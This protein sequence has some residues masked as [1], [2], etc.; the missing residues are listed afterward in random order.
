MVEHH[1]SLTLPARMATGSVLALLAALGLA[2]ASSCT[3]DGDSGA[4][5]STASG[6]HG[7]AGAAAGHG[8]GGQ[9]NAGA[10]GGHGGTGA[11]G[12]SGGATGGAGGGDGGG[13]PCAGTT[14]GN[15]GESEPCAVVSDCDGQMYCN[16]TSCICYPP[17]ECIE[18]ADCAQ[19]DNAWVHDGCAGT[20]ACTNGL[21][22][23]ICN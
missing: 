13:N 22:E 2:L 1:R 12:G 21:C 14:P 19:S 20:A 17:R 9:G 18:V 16:W 10:P 11:Q 5:A 15:G 8:G 3:D 4:G 23:W 6:G 7:G